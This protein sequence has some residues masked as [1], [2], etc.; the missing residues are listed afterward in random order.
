MTKSLRA[1]QG[2]PGLSQNNGS[3]TTIA[4]YSLRGR[5]HPTVAAPRTWEE[6]DDPELRHLRFDEVL[7]RVG[8]GRRPVGAAG[9]TCRRGVLLAS[10]GP[11]LAQIADDVPQHARRGRRHRSPCQQKAPT[12]GNN[13]SFVIQEHHARRLHYDLRLERDGVLA[14]GRCQRTCPTHPAVNH[15]AVHTEDH[16]LEYLTFA[17]HHPGRG[18]RCGGEMIV[19]DTGTYE[20]EK[21]NDNAPK[22]LK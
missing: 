9:R 7:K 12:A 8:D 13:N 1:R 20:T 15:L 22:D 18:V 14:A 2:V 17:G 16:P 6:L 19:W 21:F 5:E 4:P 10:W 11:P 3:K